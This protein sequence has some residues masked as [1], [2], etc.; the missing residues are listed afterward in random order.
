MYAQGSN[1]LYIGGIGIMPEAFYKKIDAVRMR[2]NGVVNGAWM[3]E[4]KAK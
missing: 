2:V 3:L 1:G 4:V